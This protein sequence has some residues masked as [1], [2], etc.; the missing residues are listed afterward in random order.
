MKRILIASIVFWFMACH[1]AD[2]SN[3]NICPQQELTNPT[4]ASSEVLKTSSQYP[5]ELTASER[6]YL[7]QHFPSLNL[8]LVKVTAEPSPQY[9]CIAY[10]MGL[11]NTWIN[12]EPDL[13]NL[14]LQ[15]YYAHILYGDPYNYLDCNL[16][17]YRA[18]VDTWGTSF[19]GMAH[20]SKNYNGILWKS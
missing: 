14:M 1:S 9:N 5:R 15:Y 8:N 2:I 19:T 13:S 16:L 10:P 17:A 11:T 20:A 4:L 12:P 3:E 7:S 6:S 18:D